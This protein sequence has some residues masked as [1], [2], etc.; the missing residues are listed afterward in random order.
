MT[1]TS[2]L[3]DDDNMPRGVYAADPDFSLIRSFW[4]PSFK[5]LRPLALPSPGFRGKVILLDFWASLHSPCRS[6]A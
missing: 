2:R 3:L 6:A 5:V 1:K 4:L